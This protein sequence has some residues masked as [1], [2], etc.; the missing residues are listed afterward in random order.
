MTTF[1]EHCRDGALRFLHTALVID[2]RAEMGGDSDD[3]AVKVAVRPSASIL[4]KSAP[5][6]AP[7]P[8]PT[9]ADNSS[10]TAAP[11]NAGS[12]NAKALTDAFLEK[13]IIC[14]VHRHEGEKS[15]VALAV[16]AATR[17]DIVIVDWL[18]EAKSSVK[19]KEI[20]KQ[21]LKGDAAEQGRARLV[22]IYT[23]EPGRGA[24]AKEMFDFLQAEV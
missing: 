8:A 24:V 22:A 3:A 19:A 5:A 13:E 4:G 17:A 9:T 11:D 23:S 1:N 20:V 2:D 15:S 6:A 10:A 18:L 7:P 21:I 12:L 14:G 16:K